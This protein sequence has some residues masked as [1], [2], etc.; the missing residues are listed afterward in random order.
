MARDALTF[1]AGGEAAERAKKPGGHLGA[2]DDLIHADLGDLAVGSK[3]GGIRISRQ[4]WRW[5]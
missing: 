5:A 2:N 1:I 3:P 4:P